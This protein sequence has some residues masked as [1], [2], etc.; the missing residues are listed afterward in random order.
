MDE[1]FKD[2]FGGKAGFAF[3]DIENMFDDFTGFL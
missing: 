1:F 3:D 2:M